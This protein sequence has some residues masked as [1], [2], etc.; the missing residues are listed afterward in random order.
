MTSLQLASM[1]FILWKQVFPFPAQTSHHSFIHTPALILLKT[2]LFLLSYWRCTAWAASAQSCPYYLRHVLQKVKH[3][4]ILH[5]SLHHCLHFPRL[6]PTNP[7]MPGTKS[8]FLC[9][10]LADVILVLRW[11]FTWLTLHFIAWERWKYACAFLWQVLKAQLGGIWAAVRLHVVA[12]C[13]SRGG[14]RA[15]LWF[16]QGRS[17]RHVLNEPV[18]MFWV[19]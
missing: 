1:T 2:Q 7:F 13:D 8:Y 4:V 17:C 16:S 18:S 5:I 10:C 11:A 14:G 15:A 19:F 3:E 9:C 6:P 12:V